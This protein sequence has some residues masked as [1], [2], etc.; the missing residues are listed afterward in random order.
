MKR[1]AG[2]WL[3]IGS[4]VCDLATGAA[5]LVA[6]ARVFAGL[7]LP[8]PPVEAWI[9]VRWLGLF[10][11]CVGLAG[12]WPRFA[13]ARLAAAVE[14]TTVAR[15]AVAG[16]L[17]VAICGNALPTPWLLVGT[18]DAVVALGQLALR[19]RGDYA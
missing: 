9:L 18:F 3:L 2:R 6:P 12:V 17:A 19:A 13:P 10:V 7:G 5:L 1:N 8:A 11:G 14:I 4:G 16:F 15:L